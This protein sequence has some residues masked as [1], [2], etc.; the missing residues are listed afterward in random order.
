MTLPLYLAMTDWETTEAADF[1]GKFAYMACHF[2]PY[3]NGLT[4]LPTF[5]PSGSLLIINDRI[6]V[7]KHDPHCIVDQL[8]QFCQES[9]PCGLLLDLQRHG[10]AQTQRIV[11]TIIENTTLP[12]GVSAPYASDLPCAVFA[13]LPPLHKPLCEHLAQWQGRPIWLELSKQ[14][15]IYT[16]TE[17]GCDIKDIQSCTL[18]LTHHEAQ[19]HCHYQ[20]EMQPDSVVF[21]I[22]RTEEDLLALLEESKNCGVQMAIGLYQEF[23]QNKRLFL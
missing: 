16:V 23:S 21:T 11:E 19:L 8:Q 13:E 22:S 17:E 14:T 6:P 7:A 5:L 9:N 15:S 4:D 12:V 1:S 10:V 18:P 2:A 20:I 3:S